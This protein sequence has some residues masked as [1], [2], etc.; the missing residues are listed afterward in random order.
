MEIHGSRH[1]QYTE[2][3]SEIHKWVYHYG[4]ELEFSYESDSSLKEESSCWISPLLCFHTLDPSLLKQF[5]PS[6]RT[7]LARN[8]TGQSHLPFSSSEWSSG[9]RRRRSYGEKSDAMIWLEKD[10]LFL[11]LI[12]IAFSLFPFLFFN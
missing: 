10:F 8:P 3:L 2:L 12:N 9:K 1:H 5:S 6:S 7:C 11:F 4:S